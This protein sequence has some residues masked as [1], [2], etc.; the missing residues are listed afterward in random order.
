MFEMVIDF[1]GRNNIGVNLGAHFFERISLAYFFIDCRVCGLNCVFSNV[2]RVIVY[3]GVETAV[4]YLSVLSPT[5]DSFYPYD[6]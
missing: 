3:T 5:I 2:V 6:Q 1:S 4:L